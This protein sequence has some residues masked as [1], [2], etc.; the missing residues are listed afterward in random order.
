MLNEPYGLGVEQMAHYRKDTGLIPMWHKN[1]LP[2]PRWMQKDN[3]ISTSEQR[4]TTMSWMI[5]PIS[6]PLTLNR[7]QKVWWSDAEAIKQT[8]KITSTQNCQFCNYFMIVLICCQVVKY[9]HYKINNYF[10][11]NKKG[12]FLFNTF[13]TYLLSGC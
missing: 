6:C 3:S 13:S 10:C 4:P 2:Y 1:Y 11:R 7:L 9:T 12:S 8:K 5:H